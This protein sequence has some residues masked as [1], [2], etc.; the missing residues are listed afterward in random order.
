[1]C[2]TIFP[3]GFSFVCAKVRLCVD[4]ISVQKLVCLQIPNLS[5]TGI[6]TSSIYPHRTL[7]IVG[8]SRLSLE[9]TEYSSLNLFHRLSSDSDILPR[10][11]LLVL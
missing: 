9:L 2:M 5:L 1:M 6:L 8:T 4:G 7:V 3:F 11:N 10:E